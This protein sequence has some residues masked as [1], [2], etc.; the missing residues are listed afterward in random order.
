MEKL[1]K[2][3]GKLLFPPVPI[4]VLLA[5]AA[6]TLLVY[7][8]AFE[9]ANEVVA[10]LSYALSAYA[11]A[12]LCLKIPILLRKAKTVK[13]E[14]KYLS[15]YLSDPHLRVQISLY[16]SLFINVAYTLLQLGLGLYHASVWYYALSGYYALLAIYM[17]VRSTQEINRIKRSSNHE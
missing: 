13:T 14:N 1:K 17:I 16:G 3:G 9:N 11:L 12:L 5:L 4:V 15:R 8:F 2:M 6:A 10:Y 7:A